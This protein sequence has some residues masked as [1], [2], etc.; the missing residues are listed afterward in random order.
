MAEYDVILVSIDHSLSNPICF[1]L[2]CI[3]L[4]PQR[5]AGV[6]YV[7]PFFWVTQSTSL[8]IYNMLIGMQFDFLQFHTR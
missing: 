2:S 1:K 4:D 6:F 7:Y 3:L 8:E 5:C